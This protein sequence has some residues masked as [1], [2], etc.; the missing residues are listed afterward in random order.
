MDAINEFEIGILEWIAERMH[1]GFLDAVLST[2]THLGDAGI[3]WI[4]L[5]IVLLFPKKTRRVGITMGISL[6]I[7]LLICNL[8]IKPLVARIRPYD[9]L[10]TTPYIISAE[11]DYSFPSGHATACFECATAIFI[12]SKKWGAAA[13]VLAAVVGFSR[14]Y[15]FVHYPSDVICGAILG[16]I[17]GILAALIVKFI[18]KKLGERKKTDKLSAV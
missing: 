17:D 14:L 13:Y 9:L 4:I 5:S 2:V 3:F 7:G 10:G 1:C 12:Y 11:S 16:V 15:L 8:A 6:I 18:Y